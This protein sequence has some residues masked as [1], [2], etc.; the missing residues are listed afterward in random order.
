VLTAKQ[1][2]YVQGLV[3]GLTQRKAY[4]NA[5]PNSENW[6]DSTVDSKASVLLKNEKVL[7]RYQEL[8]AMSSEIALWTREKSFSK[9]KWLLK[10]TENT[11]IQDGGVRQST[12]TIYLQAVDKL[13]ELAGKGQELA[14]KKLLADIQRA[15]AEAKITQ[16]K[17]DQLEADGEGFDLLKA[18]IDVSER[19]DT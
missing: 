9:V 17:V 7:A 13:D 15:E 8:I 18:L 11:I 14:D 12:G 3:A 5:Y 2:K 1:E 4:R 10:E 16:A 19:D 6:K